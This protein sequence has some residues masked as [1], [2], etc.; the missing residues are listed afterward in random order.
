MNYIEVSP[1]N[2]RPVDTGVESLDKR[3]YACHADPS[4]LHSVAFYKAFGQRSQNLGDRYLML[5]ERDFIFFLEKIGAVAQKIKTLNLPK[6][7]RLTT[8][9]FPAYYLSSLTGLDTPRSGR[10]WLLTRHEIFP[11]S[12]G[13]KGIPA[14]IGDADYVAVERCYIQDNN[15]FLGAEWDREMKGKFT[16]VTG[17]DCYDVYKKN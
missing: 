14:L 3:Y 10:P 1:C 2:P 7:T 13:D 15:V 6:E 11:E 17:T 9:T 8:I 5:A 4:A 12:F 16:R